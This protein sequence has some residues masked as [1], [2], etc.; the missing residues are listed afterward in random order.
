MHFLIVIPANNEAKVIGS[1]VKSLKDEGYEVCVIDDGSEDDTGGIAEAAGAIVMR[2]AVRSGKGASLRRGFKYALE[3][4][5]E[6]VLTM[7]G[8][9]QHHKDDI[10]AFME[11]A[12]ASAE[13]VIVGN[14]MGNAEHM[15]GLRLFTNKLM[16]W[17][18]SLACRQSVPD[19]QCGFRYIHNEVLKAIQLESN[20]FEIES[21]IIIKA[22]KKAFPIYSVDIRTIYE[23]EQSHIHPVRDTFRFIVYF[24][25][26]MLGG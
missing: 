23:G 19:T 16:S 21:E 12:N 11:K 15:P 24:L 20:G 10:P 17:I 6:A 4:H 9:G 14:R 25:K 3:N 18:I 8:D 5:Y 1:M 2:N 13:G 26:E 22:S 7:D